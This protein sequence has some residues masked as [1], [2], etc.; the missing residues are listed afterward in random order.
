MGR[1]MD[2][3][4]DN[5]R[6]TAYARGQ[7]S[8]DLFGPGMTPLHKAGL[9]GLWMTLEALEKDGSKASLANGSWRRDAT[10]VTLSWSGNPKTFFDALFRESFKIDS[11]GLIWFPA[12][13]EPMD[14]PHHAVVLQEA[15]LG[16]FLQHGRTR[17]S[18][19]SADPQG[20][21]SVDGDEACVPLLF[22]RIRKY[23]HQ[24]HDFDAI[25]TNPL[26]GWHFPGGAVRHVGL[27]QSSTALEESPGG[28]L[29][30]RYA[31]V[32]TIYFEIRH[33]G[34]GVR[35]KYA[36][37]I[38]EITDLGRYA[39]A[40]RCFLKYGVQQLYVSGAGEAGLR[41]LAELKATDLLRDIRSAFCRVI[42]FGTV[43]WSP[44]QKTRVDLVTVRG[45]SEA[46]LQT[47][48][49]CQ[50]VF[51]KRLVR[52]K[53]GDPYWDV[54][55]VPDL[56]ARNM[57]E[58]RYWWQDFAA[59]VGDVGRG[60]HVFHYEKGGLAKMIESRDALPGGP[61]RAFVVACHDAW[62][63]RM[64][65]LSGKAKREGSSFVDAVD[66]EF[67][68]LR[69][70]FSRCK[71]AVSL[72][73]AITDFWA[74]AG[75]PLKPLQDGWREVIDLL[76]EKNWRKARDLALL[77]LASYKPATQEEEALDVLKEP[78]LEGGEK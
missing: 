32:G 56:V 76:D 41:V 68:R 78:E 75:S 21:I 2:E 31:P 50:H 5:P 13:G 63:R 10:C 38:P 49:L 4:I 45:R 44:Q 25:R 73:E 64:G 26:A 35:P 58:G 27:G 51:E 46:S 6:E 70:S 18:D 66:R 61:E 72:R 11:N 12:L 55:Q 39:A 65:R 36:I 40:R 22:H 28:A 34:G 37:V 57:S 30:L 23:V 3:K 69:V 24:K 77:A 42:S 60:R 62:R 20:N 14:N 7:M 67:E 54:P 29:V 59:F 53:S 48:R 16:S 9:A 19:R 47:F 74:R 43:P 15:I 52:P 17:E 8:I 33:K 1:R 71:N